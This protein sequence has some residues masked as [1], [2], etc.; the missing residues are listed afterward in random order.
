MAFSPAWGGAIPLVQIGSFKGFLASR[1]SGKQIK[2][3][4]LGTFAK[5][6]IM[7]GLRTRVGKAFVQALQMQVLAR[8]GYKPSV[9]AIGVELQAYIA[10]MRFQ[11]IQ[12]NKK[13][14]RGRQQQIE[15]IMKPGEFR[16]EPKRGVDAIPGGYFRE[17][18]GAQNQ[19]DA[20]GQVRRTDRE[21]DDD[22]DLIN[23][24][25]RRKRR[26]GRFVNV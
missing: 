4:Y 14:Q 11:A 12:A 23:W 10:F 9:D 25:D 24:F 19:P 7:A 2:A 1:R 13:S 20:T 8:F 22:Q 26:R 16:A 18:P 5:P 21:A 6:V 3:W 15:K 17:W